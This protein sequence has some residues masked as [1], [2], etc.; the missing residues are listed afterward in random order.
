M[1]EVGIGVVQVAILFF[2]AMALNKV[3]EL[4][5]LPIPGSIL[6]IALLFTLL[7]TGVVK[8][9]WIERGANWL[10][11]ELLLFFVPAA[12]GVMQY[13]PLLESEGVRIL[14][15][16]ILSTVIVMVSSGLIASRIEKRKEGRVS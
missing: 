7:K 11:A 9:K 8:L 6:G 4:L 14:I 13:I 12:V 15:V 2:A 16:V 10:L 5:H 1:K 3:A